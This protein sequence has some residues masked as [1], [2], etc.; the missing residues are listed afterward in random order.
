MSEIDVQFTFKSDPIQDAQ[1]EHFAFDSSIGD[2]DRCWCVLNLQ[3]DVK[4]DSTVSREN[5]IDEGRLVFGDS[6]SF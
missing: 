6:F 5:D 2:S 4:K 3:H 1:E